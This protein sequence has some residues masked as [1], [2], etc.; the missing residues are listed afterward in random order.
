M[1]LLLLFNNSEIPFSDSFVEIP[2]N[3]TNPQAVSGI[4]KVPEDGLLVIQCQ[5]PG[6]NGQTVIEQLNCGG[7]GGG[8]GFTWQEVSVSRGNLI[9]Y[10]I[11]A[12]GSITVTQPTLGIAMTATRGAHATSSTGGVKGIA[13][14]GDGQIDGTDGGNG[15][16]TQ[17]GS[18]GDSANGIGGPGGTVG[19]KNGQPAGGAGGGGGGAYRSGGGGI[20][21]PA[22]SGY[23]SFAITA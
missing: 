12:D 13:T 17:G 2:I 22:G 6:G 20:G 1:S 5:A 8:G 9:T 15:N 10:V 4:Y 19:S 11:G 16:M 21:G 23:L 14:G 18:G 3:A 7:G